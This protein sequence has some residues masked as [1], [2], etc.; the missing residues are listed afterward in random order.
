MIGSNRLRAFVDIELPAIAPGLV[1]AAT[2]SLILSL[3]E[4]ARTS[5]LQGGGNTVQT[6][7]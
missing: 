7:L 4:T 2:F 5:I 1:G 3:N 6:Y